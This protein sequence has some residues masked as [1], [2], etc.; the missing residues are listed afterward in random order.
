MQNKKEIPSLEEIDRVLDY[1]AGNFALL[2]EKFGTTRA[3]FKH[4]VEVRESEIAYIKG[5]LDREGRKINTDFDTFLNSPD[6]SPYVGVR[7]EHGIPDKDFSQVLVAERNFSDK[8]KNRKTTITQK[9]LKQLGYGNVPPE[10]CR[11][12][13]W[14]SN[15]YMIKLKTQLTPYFSLYTPKYELG[16]EI[17]TT[18]I[19]KIIQ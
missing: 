13:A 17:Q 1:L 12:Y 3:R 9:L 2:G 7:S 5:Y 18:Y 6:Y 15:Y 14:N 4:F 8:I 10:F 19:V 11:G 16:P